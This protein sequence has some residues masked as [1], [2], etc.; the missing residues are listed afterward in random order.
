MG[1]SPST[2]C[3]PSAQEDFPT[4]LSSTKLIEQEKV[5]NFIQR[6]LVNDVDPLL[7]LQNYNKKAEQDM[8]IALMTTIDFLTTTAVVNPREKS[9]EIPSK[10]FLFEDDLD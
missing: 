1:L 5:V 7:I 4:S 3:L 2:N 6:C 10:Q 8:R 9:T